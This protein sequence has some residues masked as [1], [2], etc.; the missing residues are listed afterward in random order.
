MIYYLQQMQGYTVIL[1]K[2]EHQ[3]LESLIQG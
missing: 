3:H 2:T 1:W